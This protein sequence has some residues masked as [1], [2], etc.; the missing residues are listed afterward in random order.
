MILSRK[1]KSNIVEHYVQNL[2]NNGLLILQDN[3]IDANSISNLRDLLFLQ[4]TG[5]IIHIKSKLI[6]LILR[7]LELNSTIDLLKGSYY[8]VSFKNLTSI[9]KCLDNF[10]K[11]NDLQSIDLLA[12]FDVRGLFLDKKRLDVIANL[13][14]KEA[15]IGKVM[16]ALLSPISNLIMVQKMTIIRLICCINLIN[17]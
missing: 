7:N 16:S 12:G 13:P 11:E 10:I 5:E 4:N 6:C 2:R 9:V 1:D 3:G 14:S 15:L 8:I 17:K